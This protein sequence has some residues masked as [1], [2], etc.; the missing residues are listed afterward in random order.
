M[1]LRKKATIAHKGGARDIDRRLGVHVPVQAQPRVDDDFLTLKPEKMVAQ[2]K[3]VA[4]RVPEPRLADVCSAFQ[5]VVGSY[6][7]FGT[8]K[9]GDTRVSEVEVAYYGNRREA[10]RLAAKIADI[11]RDCGADIVLVSPV[12]EHIVSPPVRQ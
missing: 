2:Y 12:G 6:N 9:G 8:G 7:A 4:L 11:C 1:Q 10:L 3:I 5:R